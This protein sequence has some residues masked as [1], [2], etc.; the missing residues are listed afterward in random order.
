MMHMHDNTM[1]NSLVH[2]NNNGQATT[3]NT[4]SLLP[5]AA[6]GGCG[7]NNYP[8]SCNTGSLTALIALVES[9]VSHLFST[10]MHVIKIFLHSLRAIWH[11]HINKY[12]NISYIPVV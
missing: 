12:H 9:G 8:M 7:T 6:A 5:P 2:G 1:P 3:F 4:V 10:Y 11:T